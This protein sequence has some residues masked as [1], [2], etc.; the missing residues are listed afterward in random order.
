MLGELT[1][2]VPLVIWGQPTSRC[3][4]GATGAFT[5]SAA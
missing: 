2:G 1:F 5:T 3:G 4:R